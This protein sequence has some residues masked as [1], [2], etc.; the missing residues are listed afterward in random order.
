MIKAVSY[1]F[2]GYQDLVKSI[3]DNTYIINDN[4]ENVLGK[5]LT[6]LVYIIKYWN[7]LEMSRDLKKVVGMI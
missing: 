6:V 2:Y 7:C 5:I 4:K 1:K 3:P